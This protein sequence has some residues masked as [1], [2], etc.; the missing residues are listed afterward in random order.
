MVSGMELKK[1]STRHDKK[2]GGLQQC[3]GMRRGY[4]FLSF[5]NIE[6]RNFLM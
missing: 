1:I 6:Q 2:K 5:E 4:M 3:F